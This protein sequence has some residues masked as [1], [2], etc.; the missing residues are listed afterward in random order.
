MWDKFKVEMDLPY[1][2]S[3]KLFEK[4]SKNGAKN[5]IRNKFKIWW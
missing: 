3:N 2:G 1:R 5:R 4:F